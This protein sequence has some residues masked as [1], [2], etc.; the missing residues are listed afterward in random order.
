VT[1]AKP[2][3]RFFRAA[4][5][6]RIAREY[7][8]LVNWGIYLILSLPVRLAKQYSEG[9]KKEIISETLLQIKKAIKQS[10]KASGDS[11]GAVGY[12][13]QCH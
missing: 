3:R 6:P 11:T 5:T 8:T 1:P 7:K 10:L 2:L 4:S 9:R 13:A 12:F